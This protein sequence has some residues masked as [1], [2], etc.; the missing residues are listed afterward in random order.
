M[1][2]KSESKTKNR[3]KP[4]KQIKVSEKIIT[5][6]PVKKE[7]AKTKKIK[8]VKI[9]KTKTKSE[10]MDIGK[11]TELKK[12]SNKNHTKN[13]KVNNERN[14]SVKEV[15]LLLILSTLIGALIPT[16]YFTYLI[17]KNNSD[18]NI[19]K[20]KNVYNYILD[21][22]Y[23]E[24]TESDLIEKAIEGMLEGIEDPYAMY[25]DQE[26]SEEF[27]K[28]LDGS[29]EGL[30]IEVV[31]YIV[32]SINNIE[33]YS[34]LNDSPALEAGLMAGDIILKVDDISF[35]NKTS[36][37]LV[38]YIAD[39]NS[40]SF[41]I[42]IRRENEEM[43]LLVKRDVVI[44]ESVSSEVIYYNDEK[45][46]YIYIDLFATNTATQLE[47]HLENLENEGIE[48]LIID[49]RGN[50]GG[51]LSTS[52]EASSLFLSSE[53]MV[54]QI[55]VDESITKYNSTG[56]GTKTYP[57]V[58]LVD[59]SSASGSELFAAALKENGVATI[60]GT[61]TYGKGTVQELIELSDGSQYKVTTKEWLTPDGN[62]INE[63]GLSP[64]VFVSFDYDTYMES[65]S[66]D[67]D[68]Q[69]QAALAEVTK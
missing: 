38:D 15:L 18:E 67:N 55:K 28:E 39:S 54:Y 47:E 19:N 6:N 44:L 66:N 64:D 50:S 48:S 26:T 12:T 51:H 49:L 23:E 63:I 10:N 41:A 16:T 46:G 3:K 1:K 24:I 42:T 45:V 33:V 2:E 25:M 57:I 31:T 56:D 53:S 43:E 52:L 4:K 9:D 58:V 5:K 40:D 62:S 61:T 21:N 20:F 69:L 37:E 7:K 8:E 29:Y 13:K 59:Y 27:N 35:E 34:V 65:P 11:E 14:F 22:Y 60:V 17:N 36:T 32:D 30:G 68:N